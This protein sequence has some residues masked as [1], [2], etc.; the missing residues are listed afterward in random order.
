[1]NDSFLQFLS[2]TKK[3]GNLLE[4]YNKCEEAVNNKRVSLII[5]SKDIS[6]NTKDKFLTLCEKNSI[7]IIEGYSKNELGQF[8]GRDEINIIG[9]LDKRM[10]DKL[11]TL[12]ANRQIYD[13]GG[14]VIVKDKSL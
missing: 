13:F 11:I 4:G 14:D 9:I 7:S 5:L 1:M 12:W 8:I 3:S 6:K 2:I 10:K